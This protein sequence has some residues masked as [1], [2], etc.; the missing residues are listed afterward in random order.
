MPPR[1]RPAIWRSFTAPLIRVLLGVKLGLCHP[2][3]LEK[4]PMHGSFFRLFWFSC[5]EPSSPSRTTATSAKVRINNNGA[6]RKRAREDCPAKHHE[7]GVLGRITGVSPPLNV[8]W[9]REWSEDFKAYTLFH[10]IDHDENAS[11]LE[12]GHHHHSS[13][14]ES[15]QDKELDHEKAKDVT[16]VY[17]RGEVVD[18]IRIPKEPTLSF[19]IAQPKR[20]V[21]KAKSKKATL[22]P[23]PVDPNTPPHPEAG[24]DSKTL[25]NA[26]V[27]VYMEKREEQQMVVCTHAM[28]E[29][30]IDNSATDLGA[31][32]VQTLFGEPD[33]MFVVVASTVSAMIHKT[34]YVIGNGGM[35]MIPRG[36]DVPQFTWNIIQDG[37]AFNLFGIEILPLPGPSSW[38]VFRIEFGIKA[39]IC[40]IYL[41]DKTIYYVSD[42]SM[43]PK[44][45]MERLKKSLDSGTT[46]GKKESINGGLKVLIID[47]L[48]LLPHASHFGIAQSIH[49]A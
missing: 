39:Y 2:F 49:V 3:R 15:L 42:V 20:S 26:V 35:F 7:I 37:T 46:E 8:S 6:Q 13:P 30:I 14:P 28:M 11:E 31:F 41:I 45:T 1:S 18:V 22:Q 33:F 38:K 21:S 4:R 40:T 44:E 36:G 16:N 32:Q 9:G 47:T 17:G 12:V 29:S 25:P 48:R 23:R 34:T 10:A 24:C 27:Q 43:I 19:S 5:I